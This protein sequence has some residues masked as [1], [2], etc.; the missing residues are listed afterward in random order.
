MMLVLFVFM[1]MY[2]KLGRQKVVEVQ[3]VETKVLK[4]KTGEE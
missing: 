3:I 4:E 2:A 1:H